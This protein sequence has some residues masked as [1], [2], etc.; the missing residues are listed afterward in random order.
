MVDGAAKEI[1]TVNKKYPLYM[2]SFHNE[3]KI[4]LSRRKDWECGHPEI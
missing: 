2:H 1:A 4:V 3:M